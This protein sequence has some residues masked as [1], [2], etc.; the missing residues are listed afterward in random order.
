MTVAEKYPVLHAAEDDV[1]DFG[2][3][4]EANWRAYRTE[5]TVYVEGGEA[6]GGVGHEL[7]GFA[8]ALWLIGHEQRPVIEAGDV[9]GDEARGAEADVQDFHLHLAAVG[10]AGKREL[11]AQF[12]GAI[13]GVRIVRQQNVGHIV[14]H[15]RLEIREHL[16]LAAA[17]GA[18]TLVIHSN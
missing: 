18:F 16:L 10:V 12:R 9:I 14:A 15:K 8:H 13:E 17:R 2:W 3:G 5:A 4:A 7:D 11:N 1:G 6:V